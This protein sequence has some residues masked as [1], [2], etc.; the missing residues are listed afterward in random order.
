M[1]GADRFDVDAVLDAIRSVLPATRPLPLHEPR[2]AGREWEYVKDCL[3]TG[4]VSSVGSYV[5]RF[6]AMVAEC[7]GVPHAV[8]VMNGTAALHVALLLA[9]VKAGDEVL[10]PALTFIATTNAVSYCGAIPHF[11]DSNRETLGLDPAALDAYL[12]TM[13]E[14]GRSGPPVNRATGRPIRAVVPMHTF[15]LPVDM[16]GIATV[17]ERWGLVVVED[18]AEA[19][20]A[21][22]RGRP[23]GSFASI[24]AL[25]FN[26]NK[27]VTTGGGGAVLLA[28]PE[29]ARRAKHLTTTAKLP[30]AWRF[31]HDAV[32][33]NYR[34]PNLNAA[35]G[36]AQLEQLDGF[37]AAKQRLSDAYRR[38]L[39]NL[40]GVEMVQPPRDATGTVWLNVVLVPDEAARDALLGR[41][42]AEGLLVR[43]AW[44]L[45]HRL[46][47]YRDCPRAPLP[48][49]EMLE[50]RLV[51]LPSGAGVF[52]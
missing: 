50:A 46:P 51:C 1:T 44:E 4:W 34:M 37:V 39:G 32:G 10:T 24:G 45:M 7:C 12:A 9:G 18:A 42:N 11:V 38:R 13:A 2:F 29:I 52:A 15:G 6:E 16:V 23:L 3:D 27:I 22:W 49:A 40:P 14:P 19:V 35:L 20:G 25:S 8:A 26:G 47:M 31:D 41:C 33:F 5:D 30:H 21:A 48:I 36:C 43:P 28:D 17:A